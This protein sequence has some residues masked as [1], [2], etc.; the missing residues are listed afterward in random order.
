MT[1]AERHAAACELADALAPFVPAWSGIDWGVD[2]I[3]DAL[4]PELHQFRVVY[5]SGCYATG[6]TV[7]EDRYLEVA[8]TAMEYAEAGYGHAIGYRLHERGAL[9]DFIDVP[10]RAK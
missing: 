8:G 6:P 7:P 9:I 1:P 2:P 3:L 10:G 4:G 5:G